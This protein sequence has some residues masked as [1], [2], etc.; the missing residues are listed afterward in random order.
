ME[1]ECTTE[2][3]ECPELAMTQPQNDSSDWITK[4]W[5]QLLV[6]VAVAGAFFTVQN[7]TTRNTE[8]IKS[9]DTKIDMILLNTTNLQYRF[10]TKEDLDKKVDRIA[11]DSRLLKTA[12]RPTP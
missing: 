1:S 12:Y 6:L 9:L 3:M 4:H 2:Q 5:P 8:D 7:S 11:V 10:A